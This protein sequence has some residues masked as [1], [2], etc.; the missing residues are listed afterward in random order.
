[1]RLFDK[2]K[3]ILIGCCFCWP[4]CL[5]LCLLKTG[6]LIGASSVMA[7]DEVVQKAIDNRLILGWLEQSYVANMPHRLRAKLDSGA[8]TSSI[9]GRVL[10][11][12][13]REGVQ[14]LAFEFDW[15]EKN[16]RRGAN[17]SKPKQAL[18]YEIQA[19]VV[20][21]VR[22]KDHKSMSDAR[23][24]VRLPIMIAGQCRVADF[25]IADRTRFNYAILLGRDFLQDVALV[26]VRET[27][28]SSQYNRHALR[29]MVQSFQDQTE[30]TPSTS[31]TTPT[32]VALT[33]PPSESESNL[34]VSKAEDPSV[35]AQVQPAFVEQAA[36]AALQKSASK[37]KQKLKMLDVR[38]ALVACDPV[39][40][41]VQRKV[42]A[43]AI[44]E[45]EKTRDKAK[46][47]LKAAPAALLPTSITLPAPVQPQV[48]VEAQ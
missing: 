7:Q 18:S 33:T 19:P 41:I 10:R 9:H 28:L 1:M 29:D 36:P 35:S 2:V 4:R 8:K 15:F 12:F 5:V 32:S 11:L 14:W 20:R 21:Q 31:I 22:I 48:S 13:E 27:F 26:D 43:N 6:L 38:D 42:V 37:K 44:A 34:K 40:V 3:R 17:Q 45:T 23:W 25:N 39:G 46:Q 47:K 30:T 16:R 24:V